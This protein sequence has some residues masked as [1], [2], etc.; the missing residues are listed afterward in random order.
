MDRRRGTHRRIRVELRQLARLVRTLRAKFDVE[1]AAGA[2]I[3]WSPLAPRKSQSM[4]RAFTF[5][6]TAMSVMQSRFRHRI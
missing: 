4:K 5:G 2:V 1:P 6:L 3:A